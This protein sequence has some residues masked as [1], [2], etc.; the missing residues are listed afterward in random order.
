VY[1]LKGGM[2]HKNLLA[3]GVAFLFVSF[4]GFFSTN[5]DFGSNSLVTEGTGNNVFSKFLGMSHT[6]S[7]RPSR[8]VG[9]TDTDGRDPNKKG[10]VKSTSYGRTRTYVD[11]CIS[12]K[13]VRENYCSSNNR[14][15][16][17]TLNC[18]GNSHCSNGACVVYGGGKSSGNR[19]SGDLSRPDLIVSDFAISQYGYN[20]S[21]F[22]RIYDNSTLD[23]SISVKNIGNAPVIGSK[24]IV[25][26]LFRNGIFM[27]GTQSTINIPQGITVP[28]LVGSSNLTSGYYSLDAIVDWDNRHQELNESNNNFSRSIRVYKN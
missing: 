16:R 2:L 25:L 15:Q 17:T 4:Y 14:V 13:K 22:H 3:L 7:S 1:I 26:R 27:D 6:S 11:S 18:P 8:S 9:C 5:L 21:N 12:D 10:T 19:Q 28:L 24:N 20:L 23:Y